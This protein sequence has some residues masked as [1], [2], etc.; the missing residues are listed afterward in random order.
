[1][2][3]G[4]RWYLLLVAIAAYAHRG[5]RAQAVAVQQLDKL[6]DYTNT[7]SRLPTPVIFD[8]DAGI[9]DFITLMLLLSQP[10]RVKLLGVT[11][12]EGDCLAD[13]AVNTTLKMLHVLGHHD[14]PIALSTLQAVNPFP[15]HYRAQTLSMD[16]LPMLNHHS[17]ADID[18]LRQRLLQPIP[19]QEYLAQLLLQQEEPITMIMTGGLQTELLEQLYLGQT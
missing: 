14:I 13:V 1:M 7:G 8:H 11:I 15:T 5:H 17:P 9:D 2:L 12:I 3:T 4:W 10:E 6:I 19:G 18:A 16:V